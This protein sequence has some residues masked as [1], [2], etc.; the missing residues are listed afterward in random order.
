MESQ[1]AQN[2]RPRLVSRTVAVVFHLDVVRIDQPPGNQLLEYGIIHAVRKGLHIRDAVFTRKGVTIVPS[3]P[4]PC[5]RGAVSQSTGLRILFT[6]GLLPFSLQLVTVLWCVAQILPEG[7][8][9]APARADLENE[10]VALFGPEILFPLLL[11]PVPSSAHP[12]QETQNL[13]FEGG[14]ALRMHEGTEG[15]LLIAADHL[16]RFRFQA[17]G[18]IHLGLEATLRIAALREGLYSLLAAAYATGTALIFVG[19]ILF[20]FSRKKA[21]FGRRGVSLMQATV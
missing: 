11:C 12:T 8:F 2:K 16:D 20:P 6:D 15:A 13:L 5:P 14:K 3:T 7:T 10:I 1:A 9:A 19:I 17:A 18:W 21:R 4:A